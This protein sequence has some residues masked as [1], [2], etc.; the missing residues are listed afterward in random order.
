MTHNDSLSL[1]TFDEYN[2]LA[3][4]GPIYDVVVEDGNGNGHFK[5][6][7]HK[8]SV[9]RNWE[10]AFDTI[11]IY[12]RQEGFKLRKGRVE[13]TPDGIVRKRTVLCEH[14]GEYKPRNTQLV[15]TKY[16]N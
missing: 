8:G 15:S 12:A 2:K 3:L 1:P 11:N 16:I 4:D 9:F 14:S 10:E 6:T 7:L 5:E 13:K